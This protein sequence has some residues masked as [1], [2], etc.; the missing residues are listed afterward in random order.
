MTPDFELPSQPQSSYI[1]QMQKLNWAALDKLLNSPY[2]S[3]LQVGI[4][5]AIDLREVE[6]KMS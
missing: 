5:I 3:F 2:F 6:G 1:I 4:K